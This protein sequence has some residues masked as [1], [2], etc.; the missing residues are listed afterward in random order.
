MIHENR[1]EQ[2]SEFHWVD[3]DPCSDE[4]DKQ[5][6]GNNASLFGSGRDAFQQLLCFGRNT[7]G[8]LRLWVPS[9]YCQEVKNSFSSSQ[10]T[11]SSFPASPF[12]DL[13]YSFPKHMCSGDVVLVVNFFGIGKQP[14]YVSKFGGRTSIEII[15]D[16]THDPWSPW[17]RLS[18]ADWCV[19]SLRK[20]LPIP[21]GGVLWS[22]AGHKT[23]SAL[24]SSG[25]REQAA[26]TKFIGM[27]LKRQY[28]AGHK[29]DKADY[30]KLLIEG[31][32]LIA[33]GEVSGMSNVSRNLIRFMPVETWRLCRQ[34]NFKVMQ[35]VLERVP[36]LRILGV[37]SGEDCCP[38]SVVLLFDSQKLRDYI[39]TNLITQQ[40]Y[41]AIFWPMDN[42]DD[43]EKMDNAVEQSTRMLSIHCD[44][45]YDADDMYRVANTIKKIGDSFIVGDVCS[46]RN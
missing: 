31:E 16:H 15:E 19:A 24:P 36:Y 6:W 46:F 9:Y 45:R 39:R 26:N 14:D 25:I 3:F 7:R 18:K 23:P 20:T 43:K 33:V 29:I 32:K 1:W 35:R 5:Y 4:D 27:F 34:N 21:D 38:F 41:P 30:R 13:N 28:L 22:P 42:Q 12:D 17:A 8:W 44:M 40:I 11:I 37:G 10:L 2:G